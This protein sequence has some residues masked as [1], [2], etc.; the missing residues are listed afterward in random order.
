MLYRLVHLVYRNDAQVVERGGITYAIDLREGID[1]AIFLSGSFQ[2]HIYD[3]DEF[4]LPADAVVIDVGANCGVMTLQYAKRSP[5]GHVFAFEPTS[6]AFAK[7]ERNLEL[8]PTLAARVTAIQSFVSSSPSARVPRKVYSSWKVSGARTGDTHK[9]HLG[10]AMDAEGVGA[11]SLDTFCEENTVQ[12]LDLI[13]IDTD[14]H[15]LGVLQGARSTI[16]RLRPT[17]VFEVG[18]YLLE[19]RGVTFDDYLSLFQSM[20]YAVF[21]L[22]ARVELD[23]ENFRRHI[24]Q[25]S[26][27]DLVARPR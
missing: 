14:G 8:N 17:I 18:L 20:Q 15:E 13:K 12:R 7:L 19:E 26:T 16:A 3:S 23:A 5:A 4:A 6:Y 2:S 25:R 10:T 11:I 27:V 22:G 1:L 24:P 21:N 9:V